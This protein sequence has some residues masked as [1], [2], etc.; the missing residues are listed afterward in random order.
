MSGGHFDAYPY[1]DE[2]EKIFENEEVIK[3]MVD[4]CRENNQ[5]EIANEL[6]RFWLDIRSSK[7]SLNVKQKRINELLRAVDYQAS[8]DCSW[9]V[10]EKDLAKLEKGE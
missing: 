3:K 5:Q 4:Y 7:N 8:G 2:V 9:E 10:A 6:E 1:Y